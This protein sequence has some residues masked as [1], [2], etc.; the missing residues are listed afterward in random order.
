MGHLAVTL[1]IDNKKVNFL[2]IRPM[3]IPPDKDIICLENC[4][5]LIGDQY[6]IGDP[7]VNR[8]W[9]FM[10]ADR[11]RLPVHLKIHPPG[12]DAD[13]NKHRGKE[14]ERY[15]G[16][17]WVHS[18]TFPTAKS[19]TNARAKTINPDASCTNPSAC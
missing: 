6:F 10:D 13:Y 16:F 5:F 9:K 15:V 7:P 2:V 14:Q 3:N 11:V 19:K 8:F 1:R 17:F 4:L 12:E 18:K